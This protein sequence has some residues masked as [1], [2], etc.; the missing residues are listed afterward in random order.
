MAKRSFPPAAEIAAL[1][2][3]HGITPKRHRANSEQVSCGC[4]ILALWV[5]AGMPEGTDPY[6]YTAEEFGKG[7]RESLVDGFD[8]YRKESSRL[9]AEDLKYAFCDESYDTG[10]ET[11]RLLVESGKMGPKEP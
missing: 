11:A 10:A 9:C 6:T 3:K 8:G 2:E 5:E 1:F 7:R 4:A